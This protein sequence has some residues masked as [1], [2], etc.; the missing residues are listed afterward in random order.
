MF[1]R[2]IFSI[3]FAVI[4]AS[5]VFAESEFK[6][7]E[8]FNS[9][10]SL[11]STIQDD[12]FKLAVKAFDSGDY[13]L[14]VFYYSRYLKT[15][16][17]EVNAYYNRGLAY[18]YLKKY[19]L[20]LVDF[21]KVIEINPNYA[22]AYSSRGYSYIAQ[23]QFD[24]AVREY[25]FAIKLNPN[26]SIYYKNRGI[27][28][29]SMGETNLANADYAK[30]A[31]VLANKDKPN[32]STPPN[33]VPNG[34]QSDIEN[35]EDFKLGS[36]SLD[37]KNY[38]QASLYFTK[39]L[40]KYPNDKIGY[41]NRGIAFG[42][43]GK[44]DWA[45][46]DYTKAMSLDP[47]YITAYVGR[48]FIY[49]VTDKADLALRDLNYAIKLD[50][51]SQLAYRF[52]AVLYKKIG[53]NNLAA[54]D[55]AK[56]QELETGT[57]K[58]PSGGSTEANLTPEDA[59]KLGYQA[60]DSEKYEQ[61]IPLFNKYLSKY[62]N[63]KEVYYYRGLANRRLNN[64]EYAIA[65]YNKSL[66]LD[67]NVATVYVSRGYVFAIQKKYDLAIRDYTTAIK[68][69]PNEKQAYINRS[70]VYKELGKTKLS[71]DDSAKATQIEK[72]NDETKLTKLVPMSPNSKGIT[73]T[74]VVE[75]DKQIFPAY[76]L[77]RASIPIQE[78]KG[79]SV[80]GD[81]NGIL[82]MHIINPKKDSKI[83]VGVQLDPIIGY[84]EYE[85]TLS[86]K[87][88]RY[89]IFPKII[90]DW[91][92]LKRYKKPT[93]ANATF[94]LYVND[95]LVE[96]RT[97]VV[98]IRSINEAVYSYRFLDNDNWGD[99]SELFA[100][101]VNEDHEWIDQIL[102]EALDTRLVNAFSGYQSGPKEVRA[103]LFAIWYVLQKRGFKY[104]S[105]TDTSSTANM[106][107]SQYVRLFDESIKAAQANCV[108]G[109]VLIAAILKKIGIRV[110]LVL[111]PGHCFLYFDMD[112]KGDFWGFETTV[113][114]AIDFRDYDAKTVIDASY[115]SFNKALE[116]GDKR[117]KE[118]L[119]AINAKDPRYHLISIDKARQNGIN[120]ISW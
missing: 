4:L 120:P 70:V 71:D 113:V 77:A 114:G 3:L 63:N 81:N 46:A 52:R 12:D 110:G 66:E 75:M 45:I 73:W 19:D 23:K 51:K 119:P 32:V 109:S 106:V 68:L 20:A 78:I 50:P 22:N 97:V 44:N 11:F 26:E 55:L 53:E 99:T 87:D 41:V 84:Q 36:R 15:Y 108:D 102:K 1:K 9:S 48:G 95:E 80:I 88:K 83:R 62:P 100:A 112:G 21:N 67:P 31:E 90:W 33:N 37:E 76:F 96:K 103:Q 57:K 8:S 2:S 49:I 101:Y 93:P 54:A 91:E 13:D 111:V 34:V 104:S 107:N 64:L 28:Y 42:T 14:A 92:A 86:T 6:I 43:L 7:T 94:T 116:V 115:N 85:A 58:T 35:D 17:N 10:D 30:A 39:Y 117:F 40:N 59:L 69:D 82:G 61:A 24:S 98:R 38:E 18:N 29:Q 56:V 105:I 25:T 47:H 65:D 60:Y 118:S 79:E 74:P 16:P 27:A 89:R 72:A 5:S